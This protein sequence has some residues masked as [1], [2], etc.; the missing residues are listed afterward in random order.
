MARFFRTSNKGFSARLPERDRQ[1]DQALVQ[2]VLGSIE[3]S[4]DRSEAERTG[5]Q[6]RV[7]DLLARAAIVAGNDMSEFVTRNDE[8]S[9]MLKDSERQ[10]RYAEERLATLKGNISHFSFLKAALLSRFP[11]R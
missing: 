2:K 10:I 1:T 9:K 7:D 5:L 6:S 11:G 8:R 3:E 4:I